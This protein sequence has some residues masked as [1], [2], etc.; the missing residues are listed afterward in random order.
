MRQLGLV[1][2]QPRPWRDTTVP[3]PC[4][5]IPDLVARDFSAD[6]PGAKMVG[7]ITYIATWQGW[8]FL[9]VTW[10]QVAWRQLS[11]LESRGAPAV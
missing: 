10:N 3:G 4:G 1:A 11:Y 5:L 8:V 2:C 9:S 7:D 6:V